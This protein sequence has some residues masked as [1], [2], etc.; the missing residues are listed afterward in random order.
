MKATIDIPEDLYRQVRA[1]SA[2]EG[3][4]VRDITVE[5]FQHYV[6]IE[7]SIGAQAVAATQKLEGRPLPS[8]FGV[9][10]KAARTVKQHEMSEIRKSIARGIARDRGL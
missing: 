6:G 3:R 9:L 1:K 10:G 2:R 4:A 7:E 5:L 8:W